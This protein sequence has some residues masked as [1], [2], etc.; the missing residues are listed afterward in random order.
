[1]VSYETMGQR[2]GPWRAGTG[3][4]GERARAGACEAGGRG[5]T[6]GR[7]IQVYKGLT[8]TGN[9]D[10]SQSGPNAAG[11]AARRM[12]VRTIEKA[13][14]KRGMRARVSSGGPGVPAAWL[15]EARERTPI[16]LILGCSL[17]FH[18]SSGAAFM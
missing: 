1:M 6:L 8:A 12:T 18:P 10:W 11:G 17:H 16:K 3:R 2:D 14:V 5:R 9:S 7:A 13:R 15:G 4:A